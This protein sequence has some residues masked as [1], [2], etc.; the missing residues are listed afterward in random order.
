MFNAIIHVNSI[1]EVHKRFENNVPLLDPV[2]D[3]KIKDKAFSQV[4][5]KIAAFEERL[6]S[7]PLRSDPGL[8]SLLEAYGEKVELNKATDAARAE[9][10]KAKSLLQMSDLKCMKRVLRRLGYCTAADVIEV[11]G[12]IACELSR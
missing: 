9:V 3:M 2:K 7:H 4:M 5:T 10:K 6:E 11:K 1:Q 8:P 12:R